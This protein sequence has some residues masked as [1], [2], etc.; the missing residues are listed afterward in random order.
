MPFTRIFV[1]KYVLMK[2][3]ILNGPNLNLLGTRE[4]EVYG[5]LSFEEYFNQL[6][7]QFTDHQLGY[8]QSNS[9]GDLINQLHDAYQHYDAVVLNPGGY[10]HTSVA[11]HDAIMAI[12]VPVIEVHISNV[13]ARDD[14]RQRLITASVANGCI[15]GFGLKGYALAIQSLI[16]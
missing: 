5:N 9:E 15:T 10:A 13:H 11:L 12:H 1:L 3:L 4:P 7:L 14:F 6:R 16:S 2:I 8:F